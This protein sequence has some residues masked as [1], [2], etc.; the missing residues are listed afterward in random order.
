VIGLCE[1][2]KGRALLRGDDECGQEDSRISR[3]LKDSVFEIIHFELE[4]Y[5][6]RRTGQNW[7]NFV[8]FHRFIHELLSTP[9]PDFG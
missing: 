2:G 7:Y 5:V 1:L 9:C 6:T 3:L 8:A 4:H